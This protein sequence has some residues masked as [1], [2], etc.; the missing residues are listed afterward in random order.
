MKKTVLL[1]GVVMAVLIGLLKFVEYRFF[2]HDLSIEYYTGIIAIV[3]TAPGISKREYQVLDLIAQGFS[4][5]EIAE[6]LFVSPST[7]NSTPP[8]SI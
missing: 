1:Y 6:K 2:V 7:V 3:F 4:N 8:T 5:N